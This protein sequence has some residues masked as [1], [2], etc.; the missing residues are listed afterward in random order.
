MKAAAAAAAAARVGVGV[1][2]NVWAPEHGRDQWAETG[3]GAQRACRVVGASGWLWHMYG[4]GGRAVAR[5][6]AA[7]LTTRV[8]WRLSMYFSVGRA[9]LNLPKHSVVSWGSMPGLPTAASSFALLACT[10]GDAQRQSEHPA[11]ARA[12]RMKAAHVRSGH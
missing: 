6:A 5:S 7:A 9:V 3:G 2:G 8:F 11:T 10:G 4:G 12:P 1:G